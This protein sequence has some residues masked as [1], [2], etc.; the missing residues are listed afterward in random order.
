M[1]M[2]KF[3]DKLFADLMREHGAALERLDQQVAQEAIRPLT[4]P[5]RP[6]R[7]RRAKVIAAASASL[8]AV[9]VIAAAVPL[10][11]SG[12]ST[13]QT[14]LAPGKIPFDLSYT[15]AVNGQSRVFPK[16]GALP[17]FTVTPG[18]NLR[19]KVGVIVPA[20][21]KVTALWLGISK[22]SWGTGPNGPTG[23]NH[24]TLAHTRKPLGPGSH[25][26]WLRWTVPAGLRPGTSRYL[27]TA[28]Y[29]R[30]APTGAVAGAIAELAVPLPSGATSPAAVARQLRT[31]ALHA[32]TICDGTRPAWIR[33][34]RTTFSKAMAIPMVRQGDNIADNATDAVYL[35]LMKGD[36]ALRDGGPVLPLCAHGG[37]TGRYFTAVFDAAT[38]VTLEAGLG[39]RPPP[40]PLQTLGPVLNLGRPVR[41]FSR[42]VRPGTAG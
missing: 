27:A 39:N 40:V 10:A 5:P 33:A 42:P 25:R 30:Q 23:I 19:I 17:S 7:R 36:F 4:G 13:P 37:P 8:L 26:F 20:H 34:V 16:N 9:A 12:T 21:A 15:V 32:V 6:R 29:F 38:F 22:G 41:A 18:E 28:W 24:P 3:A 14:G 35:V 1:A 2:T 31:K 11:L